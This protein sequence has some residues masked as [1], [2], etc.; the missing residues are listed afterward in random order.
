MIDEIRSKI[1]DGL[2]EFSKHA[3]DQ[4]IVRRIR[5]EELREAIGTGEIIE[6]YP[7][8]KYGSSCLIFGLT[9]E[10]RPLHVQS[11][12]PSRP[13]LKII[14]LYEPDQDLWIDF[15]MRKVQDAS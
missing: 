11:S 10:R 5:I 15:K 4:S 9:V 1:A 6:D 13:L 12:Y 14:T 3:V 2:F 7:K 8:D